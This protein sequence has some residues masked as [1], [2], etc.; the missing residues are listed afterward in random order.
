MPQNQEDEDH[1]D[2]SGVIAYGL[3]TLALAMIGAI[4]YWL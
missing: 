1:G 3:A 4:F 2:P